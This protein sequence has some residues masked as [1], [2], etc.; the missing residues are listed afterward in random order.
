MKPVQLYQRGLR[1]R[2]FSWRQV[3]LL[4]MAGPST[5]WC[6]SVGPWLL[7]YGW[8]P[9]NKFIAIHRW[10]NVRVIYSAGLGLV[11]SV[12]DRQMTL[13]LGL[14]LVTLKLDFGRLRSVPEWVKF[15]GEAL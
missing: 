10:F 4:A 2:M 8:F 5:R 11:A 9:A 13:T 12:N 14:L 7:G 15:I 6:I 1:W 3:G